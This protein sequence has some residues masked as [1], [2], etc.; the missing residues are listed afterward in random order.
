MTH[1]ELA[2]ALRSLLD[3]ERFSEAEH[4]LPDYAAAVLH[5]CS[6]AEQVREARDFLRESVQSVKARRAHYLHAMC[7]QAC[8]RAY[9]GSDPSA[10]TFDCDG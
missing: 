6:T 7:Q 2:G 4:L 8:Q 10:S 9:L 3:Q 5:D 1:V